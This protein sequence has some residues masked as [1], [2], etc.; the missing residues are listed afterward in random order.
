L[1]ADVGI[2]EVVFVADAGAGTVSF[3]TTGIGT[4]WI[5]IAGLDTDWWGRRKVTGLEGVSDVAL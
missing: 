4:A 1:T 2:S 3:F 5:G